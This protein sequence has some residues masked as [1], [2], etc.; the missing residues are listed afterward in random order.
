MADNNRRAM[1]GKMYPIF[2]LLAPNRQRVAQ[3]A[4]ECCEREGGQ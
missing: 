2:A 4:P 1:I 3:A